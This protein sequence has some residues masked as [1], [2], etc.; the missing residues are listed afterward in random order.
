M[1]LLNHDLVWPSCLL[2][3]FVIVVQIVT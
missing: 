3:Y 2:V 1:Q